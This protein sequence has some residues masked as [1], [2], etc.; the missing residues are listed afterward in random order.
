VPCQCNNK[1]PWITSTPDPKSHL[2]A[3]GL[4]KTDAAAGWA[5]TFKSTI[6]AVEKAFGSGAWFFVGAFAALIWFVIVFVL[7]L[8]AMIIVEIID[9]IIA[10]VK[11]IINS[12]IDLF[13]HD[14][15]GSLNV[16]FSLD[17]GSTFDN[18]IT[19]GRSSEAPALAFDASHLYVGWTDT[20]NKVT[21]LVAPTPSTTTF[22]KAN[23]DGPAL[24]F[25]NG[26][27][28]VAWQGTDNHLNI[29]SSADGKNFGNKITLLET[30]KDN[31]TPG[32]A[33][34]DGRLYLSWI[35]TDNRINIISS[36]DGL[37][38]GGKITLD[39]TSGDD[40]TP[41]LA[42]G[43]GVLY[44]AWAGTD[45]NHP[46]NV[47]TLSH[48]MNGVLT[49]SARVTLQESSTRKAGPGLAFGDEWVFL[50]WTGTDDQLNV[51]SSADGQNFGNKQTFEKSSNDA[52]PA[53]A[54]GQGILCISWIGQA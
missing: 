11:S 2:E 32:L 35:G 54:F 19:F 9:A 48:D 24:A 6:S 20:D 45:D 46:L 42:L 49:Q 22:E 5:E 43:N 16:M 7:A 27:L 37:S 8:V 40:A 28:F 1:I 39:D 33:Y 29:M 44:L 53:L 30:S 23:D 31:A 47:M 50:A 41:A 34:G 10:A 12:F 18:K 4:V 13:S 38:W 26:Q 51:L 3:C 14:T 36:P 15:D 52:R 21:V 25:G 17:D